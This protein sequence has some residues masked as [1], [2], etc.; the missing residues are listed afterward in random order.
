MRRGLLFICY[1]V[2]AS[3][4]ITLPS[5]SS[6]ASSRTV[7]I[8]IDVSGSMRGAALNESIAA[9]NQLISQLPDTKV[10]IY[11][12]ARQVQKLDPATISEFLK[13]GII[14]GLESSGYTALYDATWALATRARSSSASVLIFTDG[15]DSR[16]SLKPE[17]LIELVRA[18]E[19]EIN[20]IAYQITPN[21]RAVLLDV[22]TA[23]GGSLYELSDVA[24]LA[25]TLTRAVTNVGDGNTRTDQPA[26]PLIASAVALLSLTI[27][28]SLAAWRRREHRLGSWGEL[29]DSYRSATKSQDAP[30][31]R[32]ISR[33]QALVGRWL[34][35]T[36]KLLPKLH[37]RTQREFIFAASLL[38]A[39][40]ALLYLGF[41]LIPAI[42]ISILLMSWVM[43]LAIARSEEQIR[44]QFDSELAPSL[45][46]IAS[47]LTAGLSFLQA[48]D[49]FATESPSIVARE[50]RRALTEVQMGAPIERAL[51]DV[52]TR[53]KSE[54][55]RWVVFAFAIQREVGG[56]LAKILRTSAE[57][58]DA[59]ANLRQEVRTL[60][61]EGRISAYVLM[62]LP[63]GLFLFLAITRPD[64]VALF[65]RESL[66]HF[67]LALVLVL[68][69]LAWVW[70][71]KMIR[72]KV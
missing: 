35:D 14:P 43:R 57:T 22:S 4:Q 3:L 52:A 68:L 55:L 1:L 61:A 51:G 10:E 65:W 8:G 30:L 26:V 17:E 53:M 34:G 66:G 19:I 46:L 63:P 29:L 5:P 56:S 70:I 41:S 50:F 24:N 72:M 28:G 31:R 2:L 71:R 21:A 36:S 54:D 69:T 48:L 18:S 6:A 25:A 27:A 20:F 37:G 16:S 64:F 47:S 40:G 32:E 62:L 13:T 49:T 45:N 7:L 11:L 15:R 23:G 12:F 38:T 9:A 42:L 39:T 44:I 67:L 58:I 33:A 60:S 59:R